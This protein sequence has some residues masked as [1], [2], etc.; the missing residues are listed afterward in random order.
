M[1]SHHGVP[2]ASSEHGD[3]EGP[4]CSGGLGCV[5]DRL[6]GA[7]F[8]RTRP[9]E[10]A[11]PTNVRVLTISWPEPRRYSEDW[12]LQLIWD[13]HHRACPQD[14]TD[15]SVNAFKQSPERSPR[16]VLVTF[17]CDNG[18]VTPVKV[19]LRSQEPN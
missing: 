9:H 12:S 19:I 5:V 6:H 4:W 7:A 16:Q 3:R 15:F 10:P 13:A 2:V 8:Y 1:L 17:R 14:G 11:S 18:T